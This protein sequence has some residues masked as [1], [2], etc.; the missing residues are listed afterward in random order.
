MDIFNDY[1]EARAAAKAISNVAE[2]Q[3]FNKKLELTLTV[4]GKS[5]GMH[6]FLPSDL[7]D[8]P[9]FIKY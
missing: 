1:F 7:M 2:H 8:I 4:L 3:E 9:N 6:G 5:A